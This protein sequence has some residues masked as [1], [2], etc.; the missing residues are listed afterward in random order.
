MSKSMTGVI[1]SRNSE[2]LALIMLCINASPCSA[3]VLMLVTRALTC[4]SLANCELIRAWSS[5]D[6]FEFSGRLFASDFRSSASHFRSSESFPF[7]T[8]LALRFSKTMGKYQRKTYD[9]SAL[10]LPLSYS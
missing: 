7:S 9:E 10:A 8:V 1:Y 4:D 2:T 3:L 6:S 5:F